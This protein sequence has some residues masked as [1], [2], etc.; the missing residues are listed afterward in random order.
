[1]K[2]VINKKLLKEAYQAGKDK[3]KNG[4]NEKNCHFSFFATKAQMKAWEAGDK[5]K[6]F[7]LESILLNSFQLRWFKPMRGGKL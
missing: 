5:G 2:K 1:M 6:K 3:K 7:D 4:A